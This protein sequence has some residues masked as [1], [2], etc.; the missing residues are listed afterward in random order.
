LW[1]K[2]WAAKE[3]IL[4]DE[5]KLLKSEIAKLEETIENLHKHC[6]MLEARCDYWTIEGTT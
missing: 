2:C 3:D 1:K 5:V 6:A 4:E